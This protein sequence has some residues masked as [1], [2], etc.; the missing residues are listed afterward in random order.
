MNDGRRFL[1]TGGRPHFDIVLPDLDALT[2][3]PLDAA[4]AP[5]EPDPG[6]EL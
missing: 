5:P 3:A 2:L 4:F 1:A 6:Q